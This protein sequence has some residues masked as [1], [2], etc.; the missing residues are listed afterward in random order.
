MDTVTL[1]EIGAKI[2]YREGEFFEAFFHFDTDETRQSLLARAR[3]VALWAIQQYELDWNCIRFIQLS[4]TITYKI[5]TNTI[6]N[7]LL[8]IHS[9]R[10][11]KE[12]IISEIVYLNELRK[13]EDMIVPEDCKSLWLLCFGM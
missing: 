2:I 5:E 11:N 10:V 4:D 12:E 1:S 8:R 6:G 7:Y 3:N 13:I 9:E